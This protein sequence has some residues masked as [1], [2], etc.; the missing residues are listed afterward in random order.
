LCL[1]QTSDERPLSVNCLVPT[2]C[3]RL[4]RSCKCR[5]NERVFTA[6]RSKVAQSEPVRLCDPGAD[7][8]VV[9]KDPVRAAGNREERFLDMVPVLIELLLSVRINEEH[10]LLIFV[11][12]VGPIPTRLNTVDQSTTMLRST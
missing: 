8:S 1:L 12:S 10:G 6:E 5:A 3:A 9:L 11:P 7:P 2:L 4:G